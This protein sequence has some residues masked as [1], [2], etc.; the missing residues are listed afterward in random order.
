MK[1]L[2]IL[3]AVPLLMVCGSPVMGTTLN[4]TSNVRVQSD[5]AGDLGTFDLVVAA[6][7]SGG[8]PRKRI[9]DLIRP[10]WWGP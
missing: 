10:P 5:Y 1:K 8:R 9:F 6:P 7:A 3:S 2:A 4:V